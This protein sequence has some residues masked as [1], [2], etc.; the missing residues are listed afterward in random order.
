MKDLFKDL[1][2]M[3]VIAQAR[4]M[5]VE[6]NPNNLEFLKSRWSTETHTF[7]A[8]WGEFGPSL[9]CAD[10]DFFATVCETHETSLYPDGE[11]NKRIEA[12]KTSLSKSKYSTNKTTFRL[13]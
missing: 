7:V 8:S 12:L 5:A 3:K 9:G 13:G 11:D 10:V 1:G 2:I 4:A 6:R